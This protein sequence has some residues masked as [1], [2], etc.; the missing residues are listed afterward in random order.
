MRV[1]D[2]APLDDEPMTPEEDAAAAEAY[3]E[4]D[5]GAPTVALD[6]LRRDLE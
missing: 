4:V 5:A 6:E 3:A 2:A 1:L